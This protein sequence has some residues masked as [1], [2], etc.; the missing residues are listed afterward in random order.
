M[1]CATCGT[2]VDGGHWDRLLLRALNR[3]GPKYDGLMPRRVLADAIKRSHDLFR[4]HYKAK[5]S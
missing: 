4:A 1:A 3:L 2:L 5:S